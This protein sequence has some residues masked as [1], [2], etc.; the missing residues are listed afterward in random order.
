MEFE[1]YGINFIFNEE[2]NKKIHNFHW[3]VDVLKSQTWEPFTFEVFNKLKDKD[4]PINE[5]VFVFERNYFGKKTIIIFSKTKQ[6]INLPITDALTWTSQLEH[7]FIKDKKSI[8]L[9]LNENDF[10]IISNY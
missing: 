9:S 6:T 1:S 8:T 2:N 3:F 4:P 10:E 5:N 7:Q